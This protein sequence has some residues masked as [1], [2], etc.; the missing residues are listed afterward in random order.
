MLDKA[1][2]FLN[3]LG[4]HPTDTILVA[5]SGGIDSM[6]LV[7]LL[8]SQGFNVAI[9]H[10]NFTLRGKESNGDYQFVKDWAQSLGIAFHSEEF[11]TKALTIGSGQS[12]QMMARELRYDF[13]ERLTLKHG[14]KFTALAHHADDRIESLL[15]NMLRGTGLR[16]LQGMPGNRGDII[17]PLLSIT[18]QEL[19]NYANKHDVPFRTD[20]SNFDCKYQRNRVRLELLP[21]LRILD[22]TLENRLLEFMDRVEN[23]LLTFDAWAEAEKAKIFRIDGRFSRIDRKLLKKHQF[24]FTIL[25][26]TLGPFGFSSNQVME[27]LKHP[28]SVSG[29]LT[30]DSH[31]LVIEQNEFVVCSRE[32]AGDRPKFSFERLNITKVTS[33][34]TDNQNIF[35][36]AH[37]VDEFNISFRRWCQGDRFKPLGMKGLKKVSDYFIDSKFTATQKENTWL[38]LHNEDI[39]WIVGHRMDDRFKVTEQTEEVL[40]ITSL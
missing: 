19:T 9:A 25:K 15:L 4:L 20:S 28:D 7:H 33:L 13:F 39:L 2:Q 32:E 6:C 37:K 5:V 34:K 12:V 14:Y 38:M 17:R 31:R 35:V 18:K 26:E 21:M 40:R 22:S 23:H 24:P 29:E 36:D 27:L 16:G 8:H 11:A 3:K 10:C 1:T 30:S